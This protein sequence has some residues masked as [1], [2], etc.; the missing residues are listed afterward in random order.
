MLCTE[1]LQ[2][3]N[4]MLCSIDLNDINVFEKLA[5]RVVL[6]RIC[7]ISY[8]YCLFLERCSADT[9]GQ[10]NLLKWILLRYIALSVVA[11]HFCSN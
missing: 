6:L 11:L 4:E 7:F 3:S 10:L 8:G 9:N 5:Q 1:L 2:K